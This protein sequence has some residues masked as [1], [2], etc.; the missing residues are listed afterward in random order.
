MA[1]YDRIARIDTPAREDAYNGWLTL[2]DLDGREREPELGRRARLHF[3][4]LRPVRRLLTQGLDTS[5][6]PS[7]DRQIDSVQQQVNALPADDSSRDL[8][9][10]YLQDVGGRSPSGVVRAT[11]DVG[12]AAEAAGHFYAAEEFY[13][14]AMELAESNGIDDQ[15]VIA[16]RSLGRV[17]RERHDWDAAISSLKRS[18][19]LADHLGDV[20]EWA[21]STEAIAAV[22]L[23]SGDPETARAILAEVCDGP[24]VGDHSIARAVGQ[25]GLCALE[26]R[27]GRLDRALE[28]GWAAVRDLPADD[29][30]RN[31]VLLNMAAA[32]RRL[33]LLSAAASC[34]EIVVRWAAWPEHRIEA[35]LEHALVAADSGDAET[36]LARRATVLDDLRH[37]DRPL[38]AMAHLTL[39]RGELIIGRSDEARTHIHEAI[40]TARDIGAEE[41][42]DRAERLLEALHTEERI[43][44]FTEQP[45]STEAAGIADRIEDLAKA[46]AT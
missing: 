14:T 12:A 1:R 46:P 2:R 45:A 40:A 15:R 8:L 19:A 38:Q 20:T 16:L 27:A 39:G 31:R 9:T 26:L 28:A 18:A 17:Q 5:P 4:A 13:R 6:A 10:R 22:H 3:L 36:F 25:A 23:R 42:L 11:I 29:E 21:R 32:F 43:Q 44:P 41:L 34:Y 30:A 37:A 24:R 33:G 35:R 7:F